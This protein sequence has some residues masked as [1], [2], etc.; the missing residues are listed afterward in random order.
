V[1][2]CVNVCMCTCMYVYECK[3]IYVYVCTCESMYM[4]M[5]IYIYIFFFLNKNLFILYC[6]VGY[7]QWEYV[8]FFGTEVFFSLYEGF[9]V[10]V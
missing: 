6:M 8:V 4:C 10:I 5:H 7:I 9:F 3:C 1:Y 2:V